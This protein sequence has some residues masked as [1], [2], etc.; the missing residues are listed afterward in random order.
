MIKSSV[1]P[2][3]AW[4]KWMRAGE[5]FVRNGGTV[6]DVAVR[7]AF[8][9]TGLFGDLAERAFSKA[10]REGAVLGESL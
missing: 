7:R 1:R 6:T 3:S 8:E 4:D 2:G 10:F 9:E 5:W